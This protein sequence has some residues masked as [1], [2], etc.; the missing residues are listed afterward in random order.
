MTQNVSHEGLTLDAELISPFIRAI[1]DVLQKEKHSK[2]LRTSEPTLTKGGALAHESTSVIGLIGEISGVFL[3]SVSSEYA[4]S[5]FREVVG[6]EATEIDD[7]VLSGI[8]ELSNTIAGQAAEFRGLWDDFEALQ[9]DESVFAK[10]IDRLQPMLLNYLGRGDAWC[11]YGITADQV[12][13]INRPIA[14]GV[15]RLWEFAGRL[16]DDAVRRGW[17]LD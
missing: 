7:V 5:F 10:A 1:Q 4:F 12:R 16:I 17:L 9:T 14:D 11:E 2:V 15:P 13:R 8:A 6:V 3:I